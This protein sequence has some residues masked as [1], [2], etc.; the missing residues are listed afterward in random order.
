MYDYYERVVVSTDRETVNTGSLVRDLSATRS[1]ELLKDQM[2]V[3]ECCA[4]PSG[5]I[6]QAITTGAPLYNEGDHL[7]CTVIYHA[8]A[9]HL[10]TCPASSS[11]K[12]PYIQGVMQA[13]VKISELDVQPG[14]A[15]WRLRYAFD[16]Y[17]ITLQSNNCKEGYQI[18]QS[19]FQSTQDEQTDLSNTRTSSDA[20]TSR[21]KSYMAGSWYFM[22]GWS[23]GTVMLLAGLC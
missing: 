15:A 13:I 19:A 17:K 2:G 16:S 6:D 7:G 18:G 21:A 4:N 9:E 14:L 23:L 12:V 8:M 22:S 1:A 11:G 10:A 3:S 20:S 5:C